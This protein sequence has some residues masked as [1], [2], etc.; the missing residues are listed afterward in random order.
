MK[1]KFP[2]K[3]LARLSVL[4]LM[5]GIVSL[6]AAPVQADTTRAET[7]GGHTHTWTNYTNAGGTEGQL[8]PRYT[9]VQISCALNGFRVANGNTWWYRIASSPWDNNF[10]ASADAFYNNG[11]TS[12]SLVGTPWVDPAVPICGAAPSA[13]S[14]P[15]VP[16]S[17]TMAQGPAAPYG[18]RY[19]ITLHGFAS[20]SNISINCFDAQSPSGFY[21]FTMHTDGAGHAYTQSQCYSGIGGDHWAKANGIESNRVSWGPRPQAPAPPQA[22][23]NPPAPATQPAPAQTPETCKAVHGEMGPSNNVSEWLIKRFEAGYSTDVVLPWSYFSG[24]PQFVAQAKS[25]AE[26][27]NVVGWRAVFPS[28]MYFA[29]GHFTIYHAKGNCYEIVD[30]YDFSA[31]ELPFW[32]QQV[33][34][35]AIPFKIRSTGKL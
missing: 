21:P 6:T 34:K 35:S 10:Y 33:F 1:Q 5:L 9:T 7:V 2:P 14:P 3:A 15:P 29:L 32:L 24:N 30:T 8:I 13:P 12:G 19:A 28:D 16:A 25:L 27:H 22:P 31:L 20:N 4:L 18:Y 26:D 11:K 23:A 17:V